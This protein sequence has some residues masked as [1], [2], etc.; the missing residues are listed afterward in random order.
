MQPNVFQDEQ[1]QNNND[2]YQNLAASPDKLYSYDLQR[3]LKNQI[4]DE[5]S[6]RTKW[7]TQILAGLNALGLT[8]SKGAPDTLGE[9]N[10][11]NPTFLQTLL[12]LCAQFSDDL[13]KA[14]NICA[15]EVKNEVSLNQ[16]DQTA[17]MTEDLENIAEMAKEDLN[18]KI[19]F[20]WDDV[21]PQLEK[22]M[23]SAF[24][25]GSAVFK[26]YYDEFLKRPVVRFISPENILV[27]KDSPSLNTAEHVT[28]VFELSEAQLQ[29]YIQSGYF[30]PIDL[31]RSDDELEYAVAI[32]SK[33]AEMAGEEE[34]Y[35]ESEDKR[36]YFCETELYLN[37]DDINDPYV[38][39]FPYYSNSIKNGYFPYKVTS[40]KESGKILNITRAWD[41]N[42]LHKIVKINNLFHFL[43]MPSDYFWGDGLNKLV[44]NTHNLATTVTNQ[45][46]KGLLVANSATGLM[47]PDIMNKTDTISIQPGSI[48]PLQTSSGTLEGCFQQLPFTQ[49]SPMY[50][51]FLKDLE[52]KIS[53]IAGISTITGENIP[54][55][56]QASVL[57]SLIEKES[58]P[59]S[60]V[61][62]RFIH[63]MNQMFII[64]KRLMSEDLGQEPFGDGKSGLTNEQV[65]GANI[66]IMSSCDPTL[67]NSSLRILQMQTMFEFAMQNPQ[68]HNMLELYKRLYNVLKINDVHQLLLTDEQYQQMQQQQQEQAQQQMQQQQQQVQAQQEQAQQ[69]NQLLAQELEMKTQKEQADAQI[70]EQKLVSD[71]AVDQKKLE[72]EL[73]KE[74]GEN[75]KQENIEL[76]QLYKTRTDFLLRKYELELQYGVEIKDELPPIL[77]EYLPLGG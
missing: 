67:S 54:S 19:C 13:F 36:F 59:M 16:N 15:V 44:I 75:I 60:G 77:K 32:K 62:K 35:S 21:I 50:Y 11:V 24:L 14:N 56:M 30:I 71:Q 52:G 38:S 8:T 73:L 25:T 29:S 2:F 23:R 18:N 12:T 46:N 61:M 41:P 42:I 47:S 76:A 34:K 28:H 10:L 4:D 45:L 53:T 26:T 6:E 48:T 72:V 40:H 39:E 1:E 74:K 70:K 20:E 5:F 55:N 65:Y 27:P 64:L 37:M 43:Y 7:Y 22:G 17:P 3:R 57:F 69:Q 63:G 49:P 51:E 31:T 66:Q 68:L 58:K 33:K 9:A